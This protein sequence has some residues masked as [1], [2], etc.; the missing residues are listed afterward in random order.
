MFCNNSFSFLKA[1]IRGDARDMEDYP[2]LKRRI[3]YFAF[4]QSE[5]AIRQ[6]LVK[7]KPFV[8]ANPFLIV[9]HKLTK[10]KLFN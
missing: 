2:L 3:F 5:F 10:N 1:V 7:T 4:V 6:K 9:S 8:I